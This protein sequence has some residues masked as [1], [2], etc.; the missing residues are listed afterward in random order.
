MSKK[1]DATINDYAKNALRTIDLAYKDVM[2]GEC[3][4]NHSYPEKAEIKAIEESG[5]VLITIFG[6]MDIVR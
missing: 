3:G 1:I 5:L 4:D 2:P 6:I